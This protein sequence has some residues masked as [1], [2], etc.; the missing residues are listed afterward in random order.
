MFVVLGSLQNVRI[1]ICDTPAQE[2]QLFV[3]SVH[4][5]Q[6][7]IEQNRKGIKTNCQP[8]ALNF[9][10]TVVA[11]NSCEWQNSLIPSFVNFVS[12]AWNM[13][14]M[15]QHVAADRCHSFVKRNREQTYIYICAR[16]I[17]RQFAFA[18]S[19]TFLTNLKFSLQIIYSTKFKLQHFLSPRKHCRFP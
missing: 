1:R 8:T 2:L 16:T 7:L 3:Y 13:Q 14:T 9:D 6:F 15:L 4:E 18:I 17:M 10:S 19:A 11:M 12:L 5:D